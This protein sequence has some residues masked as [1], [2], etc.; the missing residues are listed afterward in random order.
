MTYDHNFWTSKLLFCITKWSS[1][2][3]VIVIFTCRITLT[4]YLRFETKVS[5]SV[6]KVFCYIGNKMFIQ[7]FSSHYFY[8]CILFWSVRLGLFFFFKLFFLFLSSGFDR[9]KLKSPVTHLSCISKSCLW[10]PYVCEVQM[11]MF[12]INLNCNIL[13]NYLH[14]MSKRPNINLGVY[15]VWLYEDD[16]NQNLVTY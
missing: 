15:C 6:S 2:V 4:G 14:R 8:C 1:G 11:P 5:F 10:I 9:K 13:I 3:S 7:L 16:T 12:L